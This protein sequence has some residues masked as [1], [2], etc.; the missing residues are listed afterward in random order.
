MKKPTPLLLLAL[1]VLV[2]GC[3][4]RI[5]SLESYNSNRTPNPSP[6]WGGDPHAFNGI[7]EGSGGVKARTSTA[8]D[9]ASYDFRKAPKTQ[10]KGWR[11]GDDQNPNAEHKEAGHGE[12]DGHDHAK[13]E[14]STKPEAEGQAPKAGDE[15]AH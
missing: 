6:T 2:V 15:A 10:T 11:I 9:T 13:E 7:G 3:A 12:H 5:K 14:A 4:P 8:T 1:A